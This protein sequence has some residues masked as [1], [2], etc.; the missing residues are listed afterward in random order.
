MLT[1]CH[2]HY[3]ITCR[4]IDQLAQGAT[5]VWCTHVRYCGRAALVPLRSVAKKGKA[6]AGTN[7]NSS[8]RTTSNNVNT[9]KHDNHDNH[10]DD[11]NNHNNHDNHNTTTNNNHNN[12]QSLTPILASRAKRRKEARRPRPQAADMAPIHA[13]DSIQLLVVSVLYVLVVYYLCTLN[14]TLY[15]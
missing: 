10:D 1:L 12:N 11:N 4:H 9:N 14:S 5:L 13:P 7:N 15:Q 8:N 6:W 2:N 3:T